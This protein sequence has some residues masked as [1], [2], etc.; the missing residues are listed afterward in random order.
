MKNIVV[1]G[2]NTGIGRAIVDS[3]VSKANIYCA[4]RSPETIPGVSHYETLDITAED[5]DWSWLPE[6][7]HGFVYCPGTINLKPIN[8][9]KLDAFRQDMEVNFF[10]AV[11]AIRAALKGLKKAGDAQVVFFSTVAVQKG[12][13]FHASISA[14]KGAIEGLTRSLSAELAPRVKVNC[15]APSLTDTPLA[16][17][18]LGT[19]DR[20][21]S[22][23]ERHSLKRVGQ[24][25]DLASMATYLLMQDNGWITGQILGIDGGMSAH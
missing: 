13:P 16:E 15:I 10:G 20:R 6:E 3:L 24:P 23:D 2:G 21:Q 18:L 8:S 9:L 4:S 22:A 14:A 25:E 12:L 19:E 11:K 17:K 5:I 1:I 7:I